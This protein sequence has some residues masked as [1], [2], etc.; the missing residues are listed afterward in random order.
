M[1]EGGALQGRRQTRVEAKGPDLGLEMLMGEELFPC[2]S[3][4]LADIE[5]R[6]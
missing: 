2:R 3:F 1:A 4:R 5:I 6:G